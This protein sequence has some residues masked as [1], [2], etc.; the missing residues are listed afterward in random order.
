M[1]ETINNKLD[2]QPNKSV[3]PVQIDLSAVNTLTE[4]LEG[5]IAE[6]QKP[7]KVEHHYR[8]TIDIGSSKVFLSMAIMVLV[9]LGLSYAIGEQRQ[10]VRTMI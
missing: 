5:V 2:K 7:T 9:I 4:R 10:I 1:F 8:H 3:E 6:V